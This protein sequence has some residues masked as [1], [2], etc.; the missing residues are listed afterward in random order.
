MNVCM[1]ADE[2]FARKFIP[3]LI[4]RFVTYFSVCDFFLPCARTK[5]G[6]SRVSG[7]RVR[8]HDSDTT[9]EPVRSFV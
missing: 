6:L 4:P 3:G 9:V 7:F 8:V 1:T 2:A 5:F